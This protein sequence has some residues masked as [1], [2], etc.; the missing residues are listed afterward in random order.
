MRNFS[1]AY[2]L[3]VRYK[4]RY[5]ISR[6]HGG[7]SKHIDYRSEQTDLNMKIRQWFVESSVKF[8]DECAMVFVLQNM[9]LWYCNH[10]ET[11]IC[12]M[13]AAGLM[14]LVVYPCNVERPHLYTT[15]NFMITY[16]QYTTTKGVTQT[17][18][19]KY[20]KRY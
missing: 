20:C 18:S 9:F 4:Y 16:L 14:S 7:G 12:T 8:L 5:V 11:W 19:R 13:V 3:Y 6:H 2:I 17:S 1:A 10:L 15:D